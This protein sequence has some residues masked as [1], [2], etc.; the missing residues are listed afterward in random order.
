MKK[1][2][3]VV[4]FSAWGISCQSQSS[5]DFSVT[6]TI[7]N[8]EP[9][10]KIYL[11]QVVGS[12]NVKNLDSLV[13]TQGNTFSFKG[14]ISD[15]GGYYLVNLFNKQR[16]LLMMEGGEKLTVVADGQGK[17]SQVTGSKNMEY[18]NKLNAVNESL[19]SR[20]N[21]WNK[22]FAEANQKGDQAKM[23]KIQQD[24]TLARKEVVEKVK[25]LY[26]EMGSSLAALYG[27]NMIVGDN[28]EEEM[29]FL[30]QLAEKFKK[31]R[32]NSPQFQSF[33][34]NIERMKV[35]SVGS[36]APDIALNTPDGQTVKLSSLKGKY[37]L[38][39]FWASWCGPCRRENPNVVKMYNRFKGKNFEIFG[40][41]LDDNKDK[42][43]AAIEKDGLTWKH[44][45]D[46]KGWQSA[47]AAA[48]QVSAIPA[49]FLVDTEGKI[50][51][52]NLRGDDL[53]RKLSEVL[54]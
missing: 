36:V 45:S 37:V 35:L 17:T 5:N 8:P 24:Y 4:V 49:T 23:Q 34:S 39:D 38:I 46:L 53:E 11:A 28:P 50:V 44:V 21:V 27:I 9:N 16:I 25:A 31:E 43:L 41:S 7:Q 54:K 19:Q 33:V 6:G 3:S 30:T 10:G 47:G 32:P 15:G 1:I 14:K 29:P 48:Y 40:V 20:V 52:K 22:D 26:P 2:L 18:F 42:W 12:N 13:L 51:A